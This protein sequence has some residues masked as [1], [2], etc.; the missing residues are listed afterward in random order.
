MIRARGSNP[1]VD[2]HPGSMG[3]LSGLGGKWLS[4]EDIPDNEVSDPL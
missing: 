3:F 4:E 2:L 1:N